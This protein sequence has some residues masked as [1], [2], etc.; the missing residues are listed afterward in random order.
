MAL[1]F[2]SYKFLKKLTDNKLITLLKESMVME[3]TWKPSIK[4]YCTAC[5]KVV[6]FEAKMIRVHEDDLF[7]NLVMNNFYGPY[8]ESISN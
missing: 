8:I 7:V 6:G 2:Q 1:A 3:G 5:R 4:K